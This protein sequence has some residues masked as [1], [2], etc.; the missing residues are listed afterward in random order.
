[1]Q[2]LKYLRAEL[3]PLDATLTE[4]G[5]RVFYTAL[6][7]ALVGPWT[8]NGQRAGGPKTKT[9]ASSDVGDSGRAQAGWAVGPSG[10]S[11]N[12]PSQRATTTHARQLP[13]TFT[14]VRPMSIN[15]SMPK[16]KNSGSIG[17]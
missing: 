3:T 13:R 4:F 17:K 10:T 11:G 5:G 7:G 8:Q 12:S 9:R 1:M 15:W 16:S 6:L 2:I 14:A